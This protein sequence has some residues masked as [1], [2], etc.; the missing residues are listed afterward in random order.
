VSTIQPALIFESSA[1]FPYVV[2]ELF[3]MSY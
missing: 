2:V 3:D 1:V